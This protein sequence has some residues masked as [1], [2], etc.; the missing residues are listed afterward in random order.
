MSKESIAKFIEEKR[1]EGLSDSQ[2]SQQLLANGWHM[3][4]IQHVLRAEPDKHRNLEPILDI[5]KQPFLKLVIAG[6]PIILFLLLCYLAL[7]IKV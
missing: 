3:D 5:K 1:S 6:I 2:I 7:M 4:I